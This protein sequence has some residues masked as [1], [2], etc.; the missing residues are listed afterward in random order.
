M[1]NST[2]KINK[3]NNQIAITCRINLFFFIFGV[4]TPFLSTAFRLFRGGQFLLVEEA[5]VP[6]ENHRPSIEKLTFLVN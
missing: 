4:L 3:I 2:T 6:G 1:N 5:G